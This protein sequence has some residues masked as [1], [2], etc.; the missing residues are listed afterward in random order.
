[1]QTK[2]LPAALLAVLFLL[3]SCGGG[4]KKADDSSGGDTFGFTDDTASTDT[5]ASDAAD[6]GSTDSADTGSTNTG[7]TKGLLRDEDVRDQFT[8][9][10]KA[11][12]KWDP[13]VCR[14]VRLS[15][16]PVETVE[17]T[18]ET[19][20]ELRWDVNDELGRFRDKAGAA[21]LFAEIGP[22][23]ERCQA[24]SEN[25]DGVTVHRSKL[26]GVGD[27]AERIQLGGSADKSELV[28]A[29]KGRVVMVLSGFTAP[30]NRR[31]AL[32][33]DLIGKA[34]HRLAAVG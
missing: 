8:V 24:S 26:T 15:V 20:G 6:T 5:G 16:D 18:L 11:H 2:P 25:T 29:Q 3:A 10:V 32:P 17:A 4:L 7:L 9:K 28:I 30:S 13:T 19:K 21:K 31:P 1:M 22:G 23:L 34:G 27:Q 12:A 14:T 33:D